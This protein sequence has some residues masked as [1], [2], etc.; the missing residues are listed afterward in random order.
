M[1]LTPIIMVVLSLVLP[2]PAGSLGLHCG[3]SALGHLQS[4]RLALRWGVRQL[5][6]C[7]DGFVDRVG[8]HEALP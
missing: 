3:S 1:T 2:Y 4:D 6:A 8:V 7:L 5:G